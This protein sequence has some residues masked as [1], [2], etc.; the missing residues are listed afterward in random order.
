MQ[1]DTSD[2]PT[3]TNAISPIIVQSRI[4]PTGVAT[5]AGP[6]SG[7]IVST[8]LTRRSICSTLS[9]CR[10]RYGL[11]LGTWSIIWF[12]YIR[13]TGSVS[14]NSRNSVSTGWSTTSSPLACARS[15]WPASQDS[16]SS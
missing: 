4:A 8:S 2:M 9:R 12:M 15:R 16:N 1:E 11:V 3:G 13:T 7:A 10:L 5:I 14:I 6:N